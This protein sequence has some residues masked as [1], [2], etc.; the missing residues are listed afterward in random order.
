[1][2]NPQ[3]R[4]DQIAVGDTVRHGGDTRTVTYTQPVG[5]DVLVVFAD[6]CANRHPAGQ[7]WYLPS[8]GEIAAA[9]A[10]T[11]REDMA[12]AL[13][14]LAGLIREHNVAPSLY[15]VRVRASVSTIVELETWAAALGSPIRPGGTDKTIPVVDTD[16]LATFGDIDL[17]VSVQAQEE[18][19][20]RD[21]RKDE[22][23]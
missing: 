20:G 18:F 12:R 21:E 11:K 13:E 16:P 22:T 17:N 2:S 4:T 19:P 5:D 14:H 1:M 9:R 7:T 23:R 10:A 6:G 3:K 15:S 8:E